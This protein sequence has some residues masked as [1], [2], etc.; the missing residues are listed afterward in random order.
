MKM[1]FAIVS[2]AALLA[3]NTPAVASAPGVD[4][5][6]S[7]YSI[8]LSGFVPVICRASVDATMVDAQEGLAPLGSLNEFCNSPTGYQVYADHSP[9]LD[10][11]SLVV[12]GVAMPLS[13]AGSTLVSQSDHAAIESRSV[14]LD[15]PEGVSTGSISFRIQPI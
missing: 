11:A 7:R 14:S 9:E 6:S 4:A 10:G 13:D 15:L 8:T 1:R 2:A 5:A 12:D 3:L